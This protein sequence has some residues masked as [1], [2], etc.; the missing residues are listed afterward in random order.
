MLR[1]TICMGEVCLVTGFLA[2]LSKVKQYK[3]I[4]GLQ[5]FPDGRGF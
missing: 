2:L 4:S 3:R 1:L 5:C